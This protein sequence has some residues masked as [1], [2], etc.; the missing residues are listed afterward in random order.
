MTASPLEGEVFH[1]LLEL[2]KVSQVQV[3]AR[4]VS[5]CEC[6]CESAC[7]RAS[8]RRRRCPDVASFETHYRSRKRILHCSLFLHQAV[9]DSF[10]MNF[11]SGR[12]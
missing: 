4:A 12:N 3:V 7:V 8:E 10:E 2:L 5:E 9:Y 1:T 11:L 6:E